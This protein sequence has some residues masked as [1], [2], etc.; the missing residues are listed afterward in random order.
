MEG[1]WEHRIVQ[2]VRSNTSGYARYWTFPRFARLIPGAFVRLPTR[3]A[4]TAFITTGHD[5][6][7]WFVFSNRDV[8]S[9]SS[10]PA[11]TC[12]IPATPTRS[13][14]HTIHI[15]YTVAPYTHANVNCRPYVNIHCY[16][17][18]DVLASCDEARE[19]TPKS[20]PSVQMRLYWR[21]VLR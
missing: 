16:V 3:C 9:P 4:M 10:V 1:Y 5:V 14:S 6:I 21:T 7:Y 13:S 2:I 11:I 18:S 17:T 19:R 20:Q 15:W 8:D 12:I